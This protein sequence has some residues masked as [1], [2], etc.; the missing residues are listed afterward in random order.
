MCDKEDSV[1]FQAH[2]A[3]RDDHPC[4]YGGSRPPLTATALNVEME[5]LTYSMRPMQLT[6]L[7][8]A[9]DLPTM[10]MAEQDLIEGEACG[11]ACTVADVLVLGRPYKADLLSSVLC[12]NEEWWF[13]DSIISQSSDV[14]GLQ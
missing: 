2:G 9:C 6:V 5:H 8:V 10:N 13:G 7:F 11:T 3:D 1:R 12:D 14:V 4:A